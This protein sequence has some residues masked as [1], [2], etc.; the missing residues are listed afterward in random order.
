MTKAFDDKQRELDDTR[1]QAGNDARKLGVELSQA[2]QTTN[3]LIL[4]VKK[5][6]GLHK[7]MDMERDLIMKAVK[8]AGGENPAYN[9]D[10]N[11]A[12]ARQQE[13]EAQ[14]MD[15]TQSW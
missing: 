10:V 5:Y 14:I 3:V 6:E 9:F 8:D 7:F 11:V 1:I 13:L 12:E 15:I 4:E 2:Q